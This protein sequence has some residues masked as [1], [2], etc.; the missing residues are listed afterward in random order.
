[1]TTSII[2][3]HTA[4]D[5]IARLLFVVAVCDPDDPT[6]PWDDLD[7]A[8][9]QR[10]CAKADAIRAHMEAEGWTPPKTYTPT[11]WH[12][13]LEIPDRAHFRPVGDTRV[14]RR[15][16]DTAREVAPVPGAV[17]YMLTGLDA[18]YSERGY[19]AVKR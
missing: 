16:G 3:Q 17:T 18:D 15:F 13:A 11:R 10:W 9:Q 1:M 2:H 7:D 4:T 5:A 12:S 19:V 14:F 8:D 6:P